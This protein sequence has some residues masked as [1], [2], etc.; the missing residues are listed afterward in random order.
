LMLRVWRRRSILRLRGRGR[1]STA[2]F[3][4]G[5]KGRVTKE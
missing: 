2:L 3:L 1:L 5:N 4:V